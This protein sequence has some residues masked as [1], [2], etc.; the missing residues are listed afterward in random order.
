MAKASKKSAVQ[1]ESAPAA[2]HNSDVSDDNRRVLFFVDRQA[3]NKAMIA[4]KAADAE[5]KRVGKVIKADLGANGMDMIKAYEAAQTPEGQEAA[6]ARRRDLALAQSWAG[7]PVNTQFDMFED[8]TPLLDRAHRDGEEAG[9]RG[10]TLSNPYNEASPEGQRYAEGWHSGQGKLF[11][12]IKQKEDA[13]RADEL[14]KGSGDEDESADP[15]ETEPM[16]QAAE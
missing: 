14:I 2:G 11:A 16:K 12:G 5:V 3:W 1:P 4:K 13:A 10:D 15:F 8:R 7:M 9:L 6:N